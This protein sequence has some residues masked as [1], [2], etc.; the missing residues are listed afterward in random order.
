LKV[1]NLSN[2][3]KNTRLSFQLLPITSS[4]FDCEA[5]TTLLDKC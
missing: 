1:A 3:V 4:F 5:R 2:Q